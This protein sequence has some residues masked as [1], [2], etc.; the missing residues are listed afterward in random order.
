MLLWWAEAGVQ[1]ADLAIL[2]PCRTMFLRRDRALQQLPL[3]WARAHNARGGEVYVRP[4]RGYCWPLLFLDD[5]PIAMAYRVARHYSVLLVQT[6]VQ[7]GCHLWLRCQQ[8]LDEEQRHQA[9]QLIAARI[10]A[11]RAST[12]GEHLGRLA[13]LKNWKRQ[14]QW[15]NILAVGSGRPAYDTDGLLQR[16]AALASF[17]RPRPSA[18]SRPTQHD[19][20]HS[21]VDHSPSGKE[22]G[23]VC[24]ALQA[25]MSP[26]R[27]YLALLR[28]AQERRGPDAS[29]YA[30]STVRKAMDRLG[31]IGS[32]P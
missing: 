28:Q 12:S 29:R 22:W 9:Q 15:V 4:A 7:G 26:S 30:L 27:V 13:G 25:G 20:T 21:G 2:L 18:P 14:G 10:G 24:G 16:A 6:S 3:A 17:H 1:R 5:V 31:I 8:S 23:W 19:P 11:D 32:I